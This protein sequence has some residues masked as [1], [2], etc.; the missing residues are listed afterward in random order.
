[1]KIGLV[2]CFDITNGHG[3]NSVSEILTFSKFMCAFQIY[4][5]LESVVKT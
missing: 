2:Q 3:V 5:K 1:M 4:R